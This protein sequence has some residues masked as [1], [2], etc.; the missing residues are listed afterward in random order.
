L[1]VCPT[2][3]EVLT[4]DILPDL[5]HTYYLVVMQAVLQNVDRNFY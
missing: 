2:F 3:L 5:I 4:F 1:D